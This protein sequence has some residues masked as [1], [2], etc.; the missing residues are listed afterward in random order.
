MLFAAKRMIGSAIG[1]GIRR[2]IV[3]KIV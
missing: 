3:I 2:A 1:F